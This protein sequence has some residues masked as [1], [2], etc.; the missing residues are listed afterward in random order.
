MDHATWM[1]RLSYLPRPGNIQLPP[2][3]SNHRQFFGSVQTESLCQ[4]FRLEQIL[5]SSQTRF[6]PEKL[7]QIPLGPGQPP[8]PYWWD[9]RVTGLKELESGAVT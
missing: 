4:N 6:V 7:T 1:T 9:C 8:R 2:G 3:A 5:Q